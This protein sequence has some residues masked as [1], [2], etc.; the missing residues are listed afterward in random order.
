M[1]TVKKSK[2]K[3]IVSICIVLVIAIIVG[4][5]F[6]VSAATGGEEVSLYT[7]STDDI[8]ENVSLT[9]QVSSGTEKEYKVATVA[10]V[11]EVFVKPGDTVKKGDVLATFETESLDSELSSLRSSYSSSLSAYNEA[12]KEQKEAQS[13]A[14]ALKSQIAETEK[15]IQ[16]IE[17]QSDVVTTAKRTTARTT[18][19]RATTTRVTT[20]RVTTTKDDTSATTKPATT[21]APGS[22]ISSLTEALVELNQN[23]TQ[24]TDSVETLATTTEIIADVITQA[25]AEGVFDSDVIADRVAEAV[26][27]AVY[28]GIIDSATLLVDS[29]TAADMIHAAVSS[30]DFE[31]IATSVANTK[32]VSLTAAQIQLASQEALYTIYNAKADQTTVNL[33]KKAVDATKTALDAL[34]QQ[35]EDM[36]N[37]W[38]AAFDGTVTEVDVTPGLQTTA[39]STGIKLENLNSMAVTV[40]LSEY[41][42]H[43]VKVGMPATVTTA[44]GTYEAEVTSIAPTATGGSSSG[45]LDSVGSMAGISGLS[46]LTDT[47][48]GVECTVSIPKTDAN[49]IAGFDAD[50]EIATGEYLD[51]VVVP[52]ESIK[53][54]KTGSYV[55]VYN[56]DEGTVTKTKIETGAV[57]DSAYE[58]KSGLKVGDRIISAPA[59]DYE[60]DTFKVK[61]VE[62]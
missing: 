54:E 26:S 38:I 56:E 20:T 27:Q 40:S 9:G 34:E 25:F 47:G 45:I 6:G 61:V 51:V 60:E 2:K 3:I 49:I 39:L 59:T 48:A 44:Y 5:A 28:D 30:I 19:K 31:G 58:V 32:N 15:E 10:T 29:G 55:Y 46:S 52:I 62:Q 17:N 11:K 4:V 57:S 1:A 23:L 13:K 36:K 53:L 42:V 8:Y 50:V 18:T 22:E 35:Q 16:R 7:I 41:D 43:K 33:Q 37:G 12:V 14:N 24:I 21:A